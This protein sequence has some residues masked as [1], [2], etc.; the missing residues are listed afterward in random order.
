M[1]RPHTR[2]RVG[3]NGDAGVEAASVTP[4]E[5]SLRLGVFAVRLNKSVRKRGAGL[6]ARDERRIVSVSH[7]GDAGTQSRQRE[8]RAAQRLCSESNTVVFG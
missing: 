6:C 2:R 7:R 5:N 4:R 8:F 3:H 1:A